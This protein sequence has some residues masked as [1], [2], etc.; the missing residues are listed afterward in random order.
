[1]DAQLGKVLAALEESKL[2]DSTLIVFV[3]DHDYH[4]GEHGLWGK[5][6]CFELDARVPLIIAPPRFA[7]AGKTTEAL[8]E[9]FDL[10]PTLTELWA[11]PPRPGS[12][13]PAWC[14]CCSTRRRR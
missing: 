10:F 7:N 13:G 12:K 3:A 5:T 2:T 9:L 1:M 4:L 11:C 8:V 14:R 6:S